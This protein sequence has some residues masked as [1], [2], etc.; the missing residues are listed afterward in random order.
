MPLAELP[1]FGVSALGWGTLP[2]SLAPLSSE[3]P[4]SLGH[5]DRAVEARSTK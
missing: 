4:M 2:D 3:V 5:R 1:E